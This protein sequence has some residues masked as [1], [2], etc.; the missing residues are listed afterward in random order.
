MK[1]SL[2]PPSLD[3][4]VLSPC[5]VSHPSPGRI[6]WPGATLR[7]GG[8]VTWAEG[9]HVRLSDAFASLAVRLARP[10]PVAVGDLLVISGRRSGGELR[11]AT[12]LERIAPAAPPDETGLIDDGGERRRG[13]CAR[14][15]L[16]TTGQ[17]LAARDVALRAIRATFDRAHF[18]EVET[19]VVVPSPGLD[20]HLDAMPVESERGEQRYLST[21]PEYQMKR[22]LA[23]GFPRIFQI[24]R[25]FRRAERGAHHNPEFA[26]L[27]WYRAFAGIEA[28]MT[29]T[30]RVVRSVAEALCRSPTLEL[31]GRSVD[32]REPFE[33]LS[34][35]DAFARYADVSFEDM[36]AMAS[37]DGEKFFRVLVDR[38]E[39]ALQREARPIFLHGYPAPLASLARLDPTDPRVS[40]RF[41]L[42]L[43]GLEICNGFGELCDPAEQ[44]A[45]L[46]ADQ[47]ERRRRGLPVYPLDERF[48]AALAEG[49]PPA[50]GNALGVDR[51]LMLCLR[52]ERID[53]VQ[54]FPVAWL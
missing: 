14:F 13:E 9:E 23:G 27:E 21:S 4:A 49:M 40:E 53:E 43:G 37:G 24:T 10:E 26:M 45:R 22:L 25:A 3:E 28:I 20:L 32:L 35:G 52:L 18:V 16:G 11:D 47:E 19:P 50:A 42:Y 7:V 33:R 54:G 30:E 6:G 2:F 8:R 51:L 39:P 29:D 46:V 41:E 17:I 5:D 12:V 48:L 34:V 36:L 38:V 1:P 44:R 31:E 15:V